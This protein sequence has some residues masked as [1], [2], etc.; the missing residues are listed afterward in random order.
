MQS[1]FEQTLD[2]NTRSQGINMNRP[3]Y[4]TMHIFLYN[5]LAENELLN[6]STSTP[7]F[8]ITLLTFM[9]GK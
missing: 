6:L 9:T 4:S 8:T 1:L 2:Q 3:T 7:N 5:S